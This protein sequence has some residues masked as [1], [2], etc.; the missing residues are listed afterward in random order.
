MAAAETVDFNS[1][2][3]IREEDGTVIEEEEQFT[4][5]A[6]NEFLLHT[7]LGVLGGAG[8]ERVASLPDGIHSGLVKP[9]AG[10]MFF[11]FQA[12][13]AKGGK[14]HFWRY[15]DAR[16]QRMID[17]RYLI[18]NLIQCDPDTSRIISDLDPFEIQE[19]VIE[20][21]LRGQQ[22]R[23]ALEAAPRTVDPLQQT[24]ATT[25]QEYIN[26][27]E[28]DRRQAVAAIRFLAQPV[29]SVV[30][31]SLRSAHR[32]FQQATD[33]QALIAAVLKLS[34]MFSSDI[35]SSDGDSSPLRREELRLICFDHLS[36][37]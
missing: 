26:R 4:E 14:R 32:S 8:R 19:R 24:V 5:L 25:L 37:G 12:P 3:R 6:S 34:Q 10:G 16:E 20:D 36:A 1:L 2:R 31:K 13:A 9:R 15:W 22:E 23:Q 21:I 30:V 11:Y 27:P 29:P 35:S 28:V 33:V 7:L 18:A 17:N